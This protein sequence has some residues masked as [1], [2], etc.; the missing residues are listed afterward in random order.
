MRK[1]ESQDP[2]PLNLGQSENSEKA[3]I[4]HEE[5]RR[6][7]TEEFNQRKIDLAK[8]THMWCTA[9]ME[10]AAADLAQTRARQQESTK[11]ELKEYISEK[12]NAS[13]SDTK[14]DQRPRL[15]RHQAKESTHWCSTLT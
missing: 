8:N 14:Q 6:R 9:D 5:E 1:L 4:T 12:K 11:E 13:D 15:A 3:R 7:A 10:R 2:G